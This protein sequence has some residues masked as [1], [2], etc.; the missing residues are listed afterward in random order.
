MAHDQY[1]NAIRL[2][3]LGVG[4]AIKREYYQA[5]AVASQLRAITQSDAIHERCHIV[6][7]KCDTGRPLSNTCDL[8]EEMLKPVHDVPVT[9]AIGV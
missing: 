4:S 2:Q 7:K 6:A 3:T 1:D 9:Q 5:T 8:V